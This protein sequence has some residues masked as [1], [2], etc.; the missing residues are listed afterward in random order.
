M[1]LTRVDLPRPVCPTRSGGSVNG[2]RI[3]QSQVEP[4]EVKQSRS[5]H[6]D[7]HD[8][9][10]EATLQQLP[11]D[12]GSNAIEADMAVGKDGGL[13]SRSSGGSGGHYE[14]DEVRQ[15]T[16]AGDFPR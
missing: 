12:L 3:R 4:N 5:I 13:L 6:T 15:R 1:V 2:H 9:E 11:L 8:I 16:R 7:T 10:L 14:R